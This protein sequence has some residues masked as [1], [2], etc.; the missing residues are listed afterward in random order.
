MPAVGGAVEFASLADA[1]AV[2][3]A[4]AVAVVEDVADTI[5]QRTPSI[6]YLQTPST[7]LT[8]PHTIP[9][10]RRPL[11]IELVVAVA[12]LVYSDKNIATEGMYGHGI[13]R[14]WAPRYRTAMIPEAVKIAVQAGSK[15]PA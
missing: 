14:L 11:H 3:V 4:V 2:A 9:L 15:G 8:F 5:E 7:A 10:D 6:P 1:P 13:K 12:N